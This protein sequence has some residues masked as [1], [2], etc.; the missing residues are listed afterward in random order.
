MNEKRQN[1][2]LAKEM[3]ATFQRWVD[4]GDGD[5]ALAGISKK[6]MELIRPHIKKKGVT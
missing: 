2:I 4:E 6:A 5:E 3:I 1:A